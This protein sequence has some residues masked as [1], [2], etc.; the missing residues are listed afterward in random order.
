MIR[1][2]PNLLTVQ[3]LS[4][5]RSLAGLRVGY[6]IGHPA[7]IE[8]L[9]RVKDSF[10]SY[11]LDR[12]AI[13]GAVAAFEDEEHFQ[14][15]RRRI[16]DSRDRLSTRLR[17][18]GFAVLPSA[19]NFVF[20]AHPRWSGAQL[21]ASL[22]ERSILVRHFP[23]PARVAGYVRISIGTERECDLLVLALEKMLGRKVEE[24]EQV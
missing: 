4:K 16:M 10:N 12:L 1:A 9:G 3:T 14:R 22:R 18:L 2:Y 23:K 8:A 11:P 20:A 7:L 5:S 15:T 24:I 17:D 21:A 13:A 19:A 6:A